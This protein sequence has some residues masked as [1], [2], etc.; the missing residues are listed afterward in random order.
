[1]LY[2][3][4][5]INDKIDN[6]FSKEC[7]LKSPSLNAKHID[8]RKKSQNKNDILKIYPNENELSTSAN[9]SNMNNNIKTNKKRLSVEQDNNFYTEFLEKMKAE[10]NDVITIFPCDNNPNNNANSYNPQ[11]NHGQHH[12]KEPGTHNG[13]GKT[14]GSHGM[15]PGM[16]K[17]EK[18][19]GNFYNNKKLLLFLGGQNPPTSSPSNSGMMGAS[20][21][22]NKTLIEDKS[23][24]SNISNKNYIGLING[25][26]GDKLVINPHENI[27]NNNINPK[28]ITLTNPSNHI[29]SS[30]TKTKKARESK[31]SQILVLD[32]SKF[33][34]KQPTTKFSTRILNWANFEVVTNTQFDI[35]QTEKELCH[36][37]GISEQL[38]VDNVIAFTK[39]GVIS[40]KPFEERKDSNPKNI[41][42]NIIFNNHTNG[43]MK[44][45][46]KNDINNDIIIKQASLNTNNKKP[47]VFC[48]F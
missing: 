48:C 27:N 4:K 39:F 44:K 10:E 31:I 12:S 46:T 41:I 29:P 19:Q 16:M 33:H 47:S 42:N 26:K 30:S 23:K 25:P 24:G 22:S 45:N 20:I 1:M 5:T 17:K 7:R 6:V 36:K 11:P 43:K 9:N 34:N 28:G 14:K 37:R 2:Q 38:F 32:K 40:N 15:K 8:I 35:L 13:S 21:K 3:D 18:S